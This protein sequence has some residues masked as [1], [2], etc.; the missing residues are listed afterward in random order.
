[1]DFTSYALAISW[2]WEPGRLF[3]FEELII[4]GSVYNNQTE[5]TNQGQHLHWSLDIIRRYSSHPEPPFHLPPRTI[6][7]GHP[8]APAPSVLYPASNLDQQLVS[9][10]ML[11]LLSCFSRVRLC[12]TPQ[13]AGHRQYSQDTQTPI[14]HCLSDFSSLWH[15]QCMCRLSLRQVGEKLSKTV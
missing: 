8:S 14:W 5:M 13:T 1:M 2:Q 12:A 4:W 11:L 6:P 7:L 3:S 9:Y 10:M 15:S